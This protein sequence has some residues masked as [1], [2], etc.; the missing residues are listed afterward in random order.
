MVPFIAAFAEEHVLAAHSDDKGSLACELAAITHAAN[1][2]DV[3]LF[4]TLLSSKVSHKDLL[5]VSYLIVVKQAAHAA[6][7]T[8]P[9]IPTN[10]C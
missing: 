7:S 5:A 2:Q 6:S 8:L 10:N 1:L 4:Q 3:K 9:C